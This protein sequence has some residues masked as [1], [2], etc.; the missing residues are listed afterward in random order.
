MAFKGLTGGPTIGYVA[1]AAHGLV[2]APII[3]GVKSLH[4]MVA[5]DLQW[6]RS[7]FPLRC[8]PMV[9]HLASCRLP[10]VEEVP[11]GPRAHTLCCPCC[12]L[13]LHAST[14]PALVARFFPWTVPCQL[15][16]AAHSLP[17]N[18]PPIVGIG[19]PPV[20]LASLMRS[21]APSISHS[22]TA[23]V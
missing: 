23:S 19:L 7:P 13:Q 3:T 4:S 2:A 6:P 17:G 21:S 15:A 12:C 22:S 8:G 11:L 10:L 16:A 18:L 20:L 5:D 14:L 1:T 9:C